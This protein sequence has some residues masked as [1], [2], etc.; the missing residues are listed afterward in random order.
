M[1][2]VDD[3]WLAGIR[4]I[5]VEILHMSL[6]QLAMDDALINQLIEAL[7]GPPNS[8]TLT[9]RA[10]DCFSAEVSGGAAA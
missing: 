10:A 2:E 6:Q 1:T 8:R 7:A 3:I 4:H 9:E 5:K